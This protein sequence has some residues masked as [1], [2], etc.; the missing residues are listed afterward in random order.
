[1]LNKRIPLTKKNM[2]VISIVACALGDLLIFI[3]LYSIFTSKD[4][5]S[6]FLNIALEQNNIDPSLIAKQ[7]IINFYTLMTNT[8]LT[9]LIVYLIFH[10]AMYLLFYKD[11]S[12]ARGYV[13]IYAVLG[14]F[15]TALFSI[16]FL[17]NGHVA[18]IPVL[19]QAIL[20]GIAAKYIRDIIK[21]EGSEN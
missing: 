16:T 15:G 3:Y 2:K 8:V 21:A 11:K 19:F 10:A 13:F 14:S 6:K 4:V 7:D 1:M 12:T 5:L 20:Y 17:I 18:F 9:M